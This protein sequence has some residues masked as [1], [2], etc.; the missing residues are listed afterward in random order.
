MLTNMFVIMVLV[1]GN[2]VVFEVILGVFWGPKKGRKKA[3]FTEVPKIMIA[4]IWELFWQK[5]RFWGYRRGA[6]PGSRN[7]PKNAVFDVFLTFL[8]TP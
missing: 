6:Q 7:R 4:P 8:R 2:N 3:V 1:L 5:Q